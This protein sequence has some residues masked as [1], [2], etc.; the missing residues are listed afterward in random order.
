MSETGP[1][2]EHWVN[3]E[4]ER[5]AR[6]DTM[7]QWSAA[8]E[9]FYAPA[10]IGAGQVV[11]DFGCGPGHAAIEFARRVGGAGHVHA[12]DINAEFIKRARARAEAAGLADRITAHLLTAERLPLPDA[13]LDRIAARNTIIYVRDPVATFA[14]FRR[15]LKPGGI[16]HG[17]EGDWSLTAVE[18]VPAAEWRALV[19]A[20]SPAWRTPEIG[21]KLYGVAW[22]AGFSRVAIQVVTKPDV[23][24]R[25]LGMIRTVADYARD[26][27]TLDPRRIDAVLQ[28]VERGLGEGTYLAVAPQF[29]VTAA[30]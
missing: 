14:E 19:E 6:Y 1:F 30:R 15:V 3:I 17:I 2:L 26:G 24:G 28:T 11:A 20:A 29:L 10:E 27:G 16:A 5:L 21:R 4:P 8:A 25:L 23:E 13:A 9:A 22:R 7:Y 12:L 18:P